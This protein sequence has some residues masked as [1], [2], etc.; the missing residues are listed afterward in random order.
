MQAMLPLHHLTAVEPRSNVVKLVVPCTFSVCAAWL[1]LFA[2][3]FFALL[4]DLFLSLLLAPLYAFLNKSA[5]C[6]SSGYSSAH[7]VV[8]LLPMIS[9]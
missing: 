1:V 4:L 9:F 6:V 8:H 7:P 5:L 3:F 2:L